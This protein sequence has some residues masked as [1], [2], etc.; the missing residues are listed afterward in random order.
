LIQRYQ[1]Q[2]K[3]ALRRQN[4]TKS[5]DNTKR[6]T[7]YSYARVSTQRGETEGSLEVQEEQIERYCEQNNIELLGVYS[8][9]DSD[10]SSTRPE[11][12]E[13]LN[14]C[15][16]SNSILIVAKIDRLNRDLYFLTKLQTHGTPFLALDMP[17]ANPTM[18]KVMV[19]FAEHEN[20]LRRT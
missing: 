10:K 19:S 18:L 14:L 1:E 17:E 8:E 3:R 12:I 7:A 20:R 5:T 9:S 15:N 4:M 11:L 2:K 13:V 6:P 16:L